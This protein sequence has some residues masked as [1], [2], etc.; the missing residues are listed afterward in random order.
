MS[1]ETPAAAATENAD[2]RALTIENVERTLDERRPGSSSGR[3]CTC[4]GS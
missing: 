3:I 4:C 1:T 2:P